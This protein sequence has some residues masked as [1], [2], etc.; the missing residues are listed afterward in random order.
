MF[1]LTSHTFLRVLF[2]YRFA[3][4]RFVGFQFLAAVVMN[5][6]IFRDIAPC[7]PYVNRRFGRMYHLNIH[8]Q[9]S[10]EQETGMP[11]HLLGAGSLL[12]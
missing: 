11:S 4:W 7:S 8:G 5:V 9:Q 2:I 6:A 3:K 1:E 12:S 10:A